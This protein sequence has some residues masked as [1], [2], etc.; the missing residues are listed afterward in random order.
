MSERVMYPNG[1]LKYTRA[2]AVQ[3]RKDFGHG[4]ANFPGAR[5]LYEAAGKIE[6]W[7]KAWDEQEAERV[8]RRERYRDAQEARIEQL[9][10]ALGQMEEDALE[11]LRECAADKNPHG[12]GWSEDAQRWW[13][14]MRSRRN[15]G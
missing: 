12:W 2:I 8:A 9:E 14:E 4:G 6:A 13:D 5:E 1:P 3:I 10:Q 15:R 7:A 11:A